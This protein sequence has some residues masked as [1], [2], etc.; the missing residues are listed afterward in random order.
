MAE[1]YKASHTVSSDQLRN[2]TESFANRFLNR[3]ICCQPILSRMAAFSF[4]P[5]EAAYQVEPKQRI[6]GPIYTEKEENGC[7]IHLCEE[8]L[9]GIPS[10]ALQGWLA[11]ELTVC[12]QENR[13]LQR[14]SL[15]YRDWKLL[16]D[17]R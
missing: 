8:C 17:S 1:R 4:Y 12:R 6:A 13:D 16:I 14:Q 11:Q 7:R 2:Y 15:Q 3:S 10:L 5:T 9:E